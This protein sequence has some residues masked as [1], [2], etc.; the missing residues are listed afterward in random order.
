MIR[1]SEIRQKFLEFFKSR[2]HSIVVSDSLIP[3]GDPTLLFTTAGMV[4]F[5]SLYAGA[6]LP[7]KRAASCQKCLRAGGKGSDLENV[8]KTI[9]HHTFFEML[10]NFSFGDYF[11]EE[12]ILWGWEFLT[13]VMNLPQEKLWVSV[14]RE[15][16]EAYTLWTKKVGI[17]EGRIVRLG[18]KD[19]FW[20][21]AGD[22]GACGPSSE[23]HFDLGVER[24]C[25]KDPCAPGCDCERFLEIWNLVF[26]QFYQEADGTRKY[27]VRRGIDTGMGLERITF[28]VQGVQNNYQTDLFR[29]IL[30]EISKH[31]PQGYDSKTQM[32]YHVIADHVRALTFAITDEVLPS[33]EGRGYVLRRILRRASRYAKKLGIQEAILYKLV[34]VVV[35][36]MKEIYPELVSSRENVARIV[37]FEEERFLGT[38][39]YGWTILEDLMKT[40]PSKML[41]GGEL[42]RLYDTYGFPLEMAKEI[43]QEEGFKIDEEGF[44]KLMGEQ[45]ERSRASWIGKTEVEE[46]V[47]LE[48]LKKKLGST[49]FLGYQTLSA[50]GKILSLLKDQNV[51]EEVREGEEIQIILNRSPFYGESGGQVGDRGFIQTTQGEVE[52]CDTQWPIEGLTVHHAIV[53]KGLLHLGDE[54]FAKV[55]PPFRYATARHHTATHLLHYALRKILGTHVKQAGSRVSPDRLRFDFAHFGKVSE[56]ELEHIESLINE[57]ILDNSSLR[58]L[59]IPIEEAKK[60]GAMMFFG[61]QYG[62]VVRML[63]IG[64]YSLELCGGTHVKATGEIGLFKILGEASVASGV[65]R[66]EA[67]SG[68]KAYEAVRQTTQTLSDLCSRLGTSREAVL[69]RMEKLLADK[70]QLEK[71]LEAEQIHRVQGQLSE[72]LSQPL[73]IKDHFFYVGSFDGLDQE[74]LRTLLDQ[75]KNQVTSGVIILSSQK[76]GKVIFLV[77]VTPDLVKKGL[78][79]GKIV[80]E[81]AKKVDGKGGGKPDMAQGGGKDPSKLRE[82]LKS[83]PEILEKLL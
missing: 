62:S 82:A 38:I 72:I 28:V 21:P 35:D 40:S 57:K 20:G 1:S 15:D 9:R 81:L 8:G 17:S 3:K 32:A 54:V 56:S 48:E 5:K 60:A 75:A 22:T 39:S 53:K 37:K 74:I 10:G 34:P 4:Q 31:T 29:P 70:R 41:S 63:D 33:N 83:L 66:I 42:F 44:K 13:Q 80:Q 52:V 59:V 79:A 76:E 7:Y 14:F 12:A 69:E 64:G 27:L 6:P 2:S 61:D 47:A 67:L 46:T 25:Q 24:G 30:S 78:H 51:V 18:E 68:L 43:A 45:K 23:I 58:T 71:T 26:P 19:N 65:R 55:D 77:L 16:D 36:V 11:K 50:D 49:E 73:K